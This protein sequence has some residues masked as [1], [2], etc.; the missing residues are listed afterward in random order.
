[1]QATAQILTFKLFD[2]MEISPD[3]SLIINLW[4]LIACAFFL[5]KLSAN[6]TKFK[7]KTEMELKSN[8]ERI[9]EIESLDLKAILMK[10][11]TDIE[12]IR[13]NMHK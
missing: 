11:Q 7:E 2:K 9:N 1:M 5:W 10:I 13:E 8:N 12:R 4:T 3:T 6:I